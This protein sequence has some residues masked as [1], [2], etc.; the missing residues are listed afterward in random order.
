MLDQRGETYFTI[1]RENKIVG[2]IGYSVKESDKSG[3]ITWLF[4]HPNSSRYGL[5]TRAVEHCLNILELN[6][7]VEKFVVTTSQLA[8]KFFG[9]FGFDL[10]RTEKDHWGKG[11]DLY[12]M[13]RGQGPKDLP[14]SLDIK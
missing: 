4:L 9:K 6:P 7:V 12:L 11:L 3:R 1:E 5:G 10:I 2:G 13:E 14:C 8:Y